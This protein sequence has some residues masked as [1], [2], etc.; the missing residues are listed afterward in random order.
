MRHAGLRY[1][2]RDS[3]G[4]VRLVLGAGKSTVKNQN[5]AAPDEERQTIFICD[6]TTR[7]TITLDT[8][9]KSATVRALRGNPADALNRLPGL[10]ESLCAG[11][12]AERKRAGDAI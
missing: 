7:T 4:R 3:A 2:A 9:D 11:M 6:P 1:A 8:A 5:H 10:A 12:M